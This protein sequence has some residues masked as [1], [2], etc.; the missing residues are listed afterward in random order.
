MHQ[1]QEPAEGEK[2]RSWTE[3]VRTK[4]PGGWMELV[5]KKPGSCVLE[6][7]EGQGGS[8]GPSHK[9]CDSQPDSRYVDLR[10]NECIS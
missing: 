8:Q 2:P 10:Y 4:E 7:Q 3:K 1:G 6:A 9:R 5:E